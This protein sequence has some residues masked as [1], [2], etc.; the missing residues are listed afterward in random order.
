MRA[1]SFRRHPYLELPGIALLLV[2]LAAL[3]TA[4]WWLRHLPDPHAIE[5]IEVHVLTLVQWW[6]TGHFPWT[7]ADS[8]PLLQNPYGPIYQ[9]LCARLPIPAGS[10][11]LG[12]RAL[13]LVAVAAALLLV[14]HWVRRRGAS[15]RLALLCALL[16]LSAK[17]FLLFSV[18][19][20]VDALGVA[21]SLAGFACVTLLPSSAGPLLGLV[22]FVAAF[23][24]KLTL[25]AA[26]AAGVL[27]LWRR[28]RR[29]AVLLAAGLAA[30][31]GASIAWMEHL[32]GG[33]YLANALLGNLPQRPDKM[34]DMALRPALSLF[35]LLALLVCLPAARQ[36]GWRPGRS[37]AIFYVAACWIS[38]ALFAANPLSS[39]NY[40]LEL[41][42]ALGLLTGE[43]WVT[44]RA[45]PTSERGPGRALSSAHTTTPHRHDP[46]GELAGEGQSIPR[47]DVRAARWLAVHS[48]VALICMVFWTWRESRDL[49]AY[50]LE[51]GRAR[52]SLS[53]ILEPGNRVAIV[54]SVS[55]R[56]ALNRRAA[57][58]P[59][60]PLRDR[61]DLRRGL[62]TTPGWISLPSPLE[63]DPEIL[64]IL[65]QGLG[66]GNIDR[67]LVPAT[68][69]DGWSSWS[70]RELL[71]IAT[72]QPRRRSLI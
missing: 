44:G 38:A 2:G 7:P 17:P 31:L 41:Y 9:W 21:L 6:R 22:C 20:R 29:R 40:L 4:I 42:L 16:P 13:S 14:G 26:P 55:G 1:A 62:R 8:L 68:S 27:W 61:A 45:A 46:P 37:P 25:I 11:Y 57:A 53:A 60:Q 71:P 10:P 70:G 59:I 32:S 12:G 15:R 56:D 51:Y 18:L 63:D 28:D 64:E 69:G 43:L 54:G 19:Y 36:R 30:G 34:L 50:H 33:S 49:A 72:P 48:A 23:N 5:R 52:R 58:G 66:A 3:L 24:V 67:V 47:L 39:W 35:W 65:R